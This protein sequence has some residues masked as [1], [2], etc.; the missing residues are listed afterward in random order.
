MLHV[1][2]PRLLTDPTLSCAVSF[3]FLCV[4]FLF[5]WAGKGSLAGM[6]GANYRE[7]GTADSLDHRLA[8]VSK[9]LL[10]AG[11]IQRGLEANETFTSGPQ[12]DHLYG[13]ATAEELS[14]KEEVRVCRPLVK[15]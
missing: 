6:S 5:V 12:P 13:L 2:L 3:V 8:A 1:I 9:C 14:D 10:L 11:G 7:F 15:E 4:F